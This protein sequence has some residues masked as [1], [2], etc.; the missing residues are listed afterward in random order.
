MLR[1]LAFA[2]NRIRSLLFFSAIRQIQCVIL[3]FQRSIALL[4]VWIIPAV[5]LVQAVISEYM[6]LLS[7]TGTK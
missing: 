2:T 7:V 1:F 6:N 4:A 5:D 3:L